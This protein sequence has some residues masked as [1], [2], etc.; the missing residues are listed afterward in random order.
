MS[1]YEATGRTIDEAVESALSSLGIRRENAIINVIE[2]PSTGLLGLLGNKLAKVVVKAAI[3]PEEYL[4]KYLYEL[5][6]KMEVKSSVEIVTDDEKI[7]AMILGNDVGILI[8]RRGRTLSDLQY[9]IN[10]IMRRQFPALNKMT[11]IDIEHYR[12]KREK[13]LTQLAK[14]VARKVSEDGY[15]QSLEPMTPQERRIIHIALQ[16]HPGVTTQ[17]AGQ[18]PYR[19]VIIMPR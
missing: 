18:E 17:S 9:L 6:E 10:V 13:T 11:I 2:E 12:K 14:N 8:G 1:E 15:E 7:E 5:L 3:S 19:K 4:E 16:E